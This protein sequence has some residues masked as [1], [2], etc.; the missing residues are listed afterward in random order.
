ML[1]NDQNPK[2]FINLTHNWHHHGGFIVEL[3]DCAD[4]TV[5]P[6][7]VQFH[8]VEA[9]VDGGTV[10][11]PNGEGIVSMVSS[12]GKAFSWPTE[13]VVNIQNTHGQLL[14]VNDAHR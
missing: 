3:T 4:R 13:C 2:G 1:R 12:C 6:T 8:G 5:A 10:E 9:I 7:T 14:W 11:S